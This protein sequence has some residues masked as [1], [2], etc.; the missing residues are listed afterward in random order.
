[1]PLGTL[2]AAQFA[3]NGNANQSVEY[4]IWA[5]MSPEQRLAIGP[6]DF[7]LDFPGRTRFGGFSLSLNLGRGLARALVPQLG[8]LYIVTQ[9]TL[10][11][12]FLAKKIR[13]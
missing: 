13:L 2:T 8:R 6:G 1:M 11:F 4:R 9:A 12:T 3:L 7:E 5:S 10:E